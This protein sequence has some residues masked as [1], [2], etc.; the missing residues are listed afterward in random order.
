MVLFQFKRNRCQKKMRFKLL[1]AGIL[2]VDVTWITLDIQATSPILKLYLETN[3]LLTPDPSPD[4]ASFP[5]DLHPSSRNT[6]PIRE[7]MPFKQ[8]ILFLI[9]SSI[10]IVSATCLDYNVSNWIKRPSLVSVFRGALSV[11]SL[12]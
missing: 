9:A 3:F 7:C 6:V 8:F 2:C 1:Q 10:F 12:M 5:S 11:G 4:V